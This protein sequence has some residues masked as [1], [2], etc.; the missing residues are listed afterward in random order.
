MSCSGFPKLLIFSVI[1]SLVGYYAQPYLGMSHAPAASVFATGLLVG[2]LLGGLLA[3]CRRQ[4]GQQRAAGRASGNTTIYV[5]NLP[6]SAGKEEVKNIFAPYG[7]VAEV[8]IVKDRRS[9]R[10][11]GYGFVEMAARDAKSAIE[12]LNGTEYAGR[13]LRINEAQEKNPDH[14]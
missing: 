12:H 9:R 6:F 10:S 14:S 2:A 11:K 5:G 8:R 7:K 3:S 4:E 1:V 13:T